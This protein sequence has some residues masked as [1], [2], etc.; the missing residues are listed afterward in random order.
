MRTP[1]ILLCLAFGLATAFADEIPLPRQ[2]LSFFPHKQHQKT[3]G[4]CSD[5]HGASDPG[6]I[7][8]FSSTWAHNTCIGCHR[9]GQS[10]PHECGGC[11]T[12]Y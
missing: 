6:K 12:V 3:L 4:G 8:Q 9:D 2:S 7:E 11:H 1:V 5:C 10:G